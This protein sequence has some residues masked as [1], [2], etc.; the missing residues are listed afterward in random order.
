MDGEPRH[1]DRPRAPDEAQG[2]ASASTSGS[3][4]TTSGA[5][6]A[7]ASS[8][9]V[10]A[11]SSACRARRSISGSAS[12]PRFCRSLTNN[13]YIIRVGFDTLLYMLLAL[14]LN[15]VVGYAGLLDL[16]YIAFYG[17]GA[18]ATRCS[19]RRSSACTG[20]RSSIIP[21]V[22]DR[23][24]APRASRRAA[25]AAPARRLPRDRHALLRPVLRH[26]LPER[27]TGSR[28]SGLTRR[29]DVTGGPNGIPNID[30]FDT[31]RPQDQLDPGLL[32]RRARR[33]HARALVRL[34]R[35]P[36]AHRPRVEVAARGS[37]RR[38]ADGHARQPAEARRVRVR[39][40]D[41]RA[42]RARSSPALN[43]AVFSADFDVPTLIIVYAMLIL[44][45]A[46]SLGGVILGALVV[47]VSLEVLR[48][49]GH[50][51]WIFYVAISLRRCSRR[52]GRGGG[53]RRRRRHGRPS[54]TPRT[55]SSD[56]A[57]PRGVDGA[58]SVG[59]RLGSCPPRL[60]APS[61]RTR[62]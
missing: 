37:A 4:R 32:L 25:V 14:G 18:T 35:R 42:R 46:G 16:G 11:S 57:W 36:V 47:N 48:T 3:R 55:R 59:G 49:P 29:Y 5:S 50:A 19:P 22:V 20:T 21:V 38:R 7:Q 6:A 62:A 17:F 27:R 10:R 51:T 44:G 34:S 56:A 15:I 61:R 60:G 13:G 23:D 53:S 26:R 58:A 1:P 43:T 9:A 8:A 28:S 31:R 2:R 39:C 30:N 45:G 40:R 54:A 52:S 33:L 24:R 41:R 12:R